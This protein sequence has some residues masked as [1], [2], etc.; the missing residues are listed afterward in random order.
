MQPGPGKAGSLV[1]LALYLV[2]V[3]FVWWFLLWAALNWPVSIIWWLLLIGFSLGILR[4]LSVAI[5]DIAA[6]WAPNEGAAG[7]TTDTG[8]ALAQHKNSGELYIVRYRGNE[9]I[10]GAGPIDPRALLGE[11]PEDALERPT[12]ELYDRIGA[13]EVGAGY[14]SWLRAASGAELLSYPIGVR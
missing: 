9:I 14:A 13:W 4:G 8:N 2:V 11:D 5:S 6:A 1:A 3:P 10:A 12:H 7:Y